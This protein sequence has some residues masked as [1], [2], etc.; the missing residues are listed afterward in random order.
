MVARIAEAVH[1]AHQRGVIHRDLKPGNII[2]D[3]TGQPKV[4]DFGIAR[5]IDSDTRATSQTDVGQLIGT[6]TYMSP[7]QTL[8]DPLEIDT[9]SDVY[10]LGVIL[11]ELLAGRLPYSA[12]KTLPDTV[13]A[14]RDEEPVRLGL[15]NR[16]YRGDIE[17]IVAT[18]L[19]KDRTRR[20]GSAADLAA[21]IRR[22]LPTSRSWHD[23]RRL[24]INSGSSRGA[25]GRWWQA[26]RRCSSFS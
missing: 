4:L 1:H 2:V 10:A 21:D 24:P 13:R 11:Y 20:Y 9:R 18:A 17:T 26:W 7:E 5:A 25:T 3:E 19:E 15:V 6:L 23:R 16:R 22:Y 8:A 12:A 14:I